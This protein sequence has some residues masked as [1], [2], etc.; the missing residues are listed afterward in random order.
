MGEEVS[1]A[2]KALG[3]RQLYALF[4]LTWLAVNAGPVH[5]HLDRLRHTCHMLYTPNMRMN[6]F[7]HTGHTLFLKGSGVKFLD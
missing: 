7:T 1:T 5:L 4:S 3:D 2:L 6:Q